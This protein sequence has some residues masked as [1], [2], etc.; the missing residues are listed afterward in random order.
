[1]LNDCVTILTQQQNE[2]NLQ[3]YKS[4]S[5]YLISKLGRKKR[6]TKF[7]FRIRGINERRLQLP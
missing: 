2:N 1:M 5:P 6:K 7:V 3:Y 4:I